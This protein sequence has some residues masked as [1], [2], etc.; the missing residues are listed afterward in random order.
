[1]RSAP[2][3]LL[4]SGE[5][6]GDLHAAQLIRCLRERIPG[7]RVLALGGD[8]CREAGAELLFHYHDY[9]VLGVTDVLS[10]LPRFLHLE[11]S[12]KRCLRDGVDLHIPVD[13]PGLNLRLASYA[14][15]RGVPVLYYISPQVW[16]WGAG[17]LDKIARSVDRM[18]VILPFEVDLYR[19]RGIPAEFVGH[20]FVA[21]HELP[22]PLPEG[23]RDGV[24][25]L[26]GSRVQEVRRILPVLLKA[27][28]RVAD[29][30]PGVRFTVGRSPGVPETLYE[31][32]IAGAG[33]SD[34]EVD[35]DAVAVMRRSR[36]L[37]V[38][39]GTAT[40]Q[41]AL[42]ETP[43][44]IVYKASALNYFLGRRLVK[45][46]NIGLVNVILGEAVCPEFIQGAAEPRRIASAARE[47]LADGG[48][49]QEMVGRFKR[50]RRMLS[51][52]AGCTRVA[53]IAAELLE[54]P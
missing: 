33:A 1:M 51:G 19:R 28:K 7:A 32:I 49:R 41:G 2:T 21:D 40:L 31:R 44:V 12:L 34:I 10:N 4:T 23:E 54:A 26:P 45:I 8:R 6:S 11:R 18:A 3:I 47:L 9:A 15:G 52:G 42:L 36:L 50:L 17:R 46:P 27:A 14:K 22:D 25:L 38:A 35:D 39:S 53:E 37:L 16:A 20:P 48:P 13:Y 30:Y 5:M 43:L 29:E 24:G